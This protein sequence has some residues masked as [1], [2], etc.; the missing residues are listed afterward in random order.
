MKKSNVIKFIIGVIAL[1]ILIFI[2]TGCASWVVQPQKVI[3]L[4][5]ERIF[6]VPAGQKIEVLLDKKPL[7]MTFP[8]D[9]KLVSPTLLVRQEQ[10]LNNLTYKQIKSE[11]TTSGLMTFLTA[12]FGAIGGIV[13]IW[14]KN[15]GATKK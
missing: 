5:E 7:S 12:I 11:K 1:G 3:L 14:L 13:G 8:E 2:L 6:T 9:M 4:P 10:Q 15:K